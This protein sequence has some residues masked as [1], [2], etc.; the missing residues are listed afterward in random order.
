MMHEEISLY[1]RGKSSERQSS[2]ATK[3][4]IGRVYCERTF[5]AAIAKL[6]NGLYNI[7]KALERVDM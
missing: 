6:I 5:P 4:R 2:S 3:K 1:E 7:V